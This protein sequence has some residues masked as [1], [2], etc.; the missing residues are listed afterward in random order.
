MN[1]KRTRNY[2]DLFAIM[3]NSQKSQKYI[4]NVSYMYLTLKIKFQREWEL[5]LKLENI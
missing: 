2:Y 3:F 1:A 4:E 5:L